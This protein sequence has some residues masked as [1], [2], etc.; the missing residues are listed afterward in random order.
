MNLDHQSDA[1]GNSDLLPG[2]GECVT[3]VVKQG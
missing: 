3:V 2:K 1:Y